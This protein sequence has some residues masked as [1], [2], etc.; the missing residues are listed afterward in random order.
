MIAA[1]NSDP[2]E[3]KFT[4]TVLLNEIDLDFS[5]LLALNTET[6][7]NMQLGPLLHTQTI[8]QCLMSAAEILSFTE[9]SISVADVVPPSLTGF[10]DSGI[11][12]IVTKGAE[13]LFDMYES[14]LLKAMPNF[15]HT[16]VR[17]K[18]NAF[19][20]NSLQ[21]LTV[22]ENDSSV[23]G[24]IDFRDLFLS[25]E[26][27][28]SEGASGNSPYGNVVNWVWDLVNTV[29]FSAN[30]SGLLAMND[31][32]IKPLTKA[33]SGQEGLVS[34]NHSLVDLKK[35]HFRH[36]IWNAFADHLRLGMSNLRLNGLDTFREP[37]HIIKPS[38]KSG[39]VLENHITLG[40]DEKSLDASFQFDI[41]VGS[42]D[43]PIATKNTMDLQV[44]LPSN[45]EVVADLFAAVDASQFMKMPLKNI[46][47]V[48]CWLSMMAD[49]EDSD[50]VKLALHYFDMVFD[51]FTAKSSCISCSNKALKDFDEMMDFLDANDFFANVNS[52]GRLIL[53]EILE[54]DWMG[55]LFDSEIQAAALRCPSDSDLT[56]SQI[57]ENS[58][59][60]ETSRQLVDGILY[61]SMSVAQIIAVVLAQKHADVELPVDVAIELDVP[62]DANLID[63]TNL[64]NV[65]SWA[66]MALEEANAYLGSV[67]N[68]NEGKDVLG[69]VNILRSLILDDDGLFTIDIANQGFEAGGVVL[70]L[71][72]VSLIG[73]DSFTSFDV[74]NATGA[75][76]LK[77]TAKL[78]TL[79]VS[80]SMGLSVGE[81]NELETITASL[82]LK[83]IEVDVSFLVALDEGVLGDLKLGSIMDTSNI[84]YCIRSA[85]HTIGE[86]AG[87]VDLASLFCSLPSSIH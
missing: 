2:I 55:G 73:L 26:I 10:L 71:Y 76:Q 53:S 60:F 40:I 84:F 4:V 27:A 8:M 11:D 6:L 87:V 72:N 34:F 80:V 83:D 35:E 64:T 41:E 32:L 30:E 52:R 47:N 58:F 33:Q 25:P 62:A 17:E 9:L 22:C 70:S 82:V 7:G 45:I 66:D 75:Q 74:L 50:A 37:F 21:V 12:K 5:F 49:T 48:N 18:L 13:A 44:S 69:I 16:F 43:S 78:D 29:L 3:E 24:L 51:D 68:N 57:V 15:F 54:S 19:V 38:N 56:S 77:N 65:A 39:R 14:V 28:S 59:P 85:I 20:K 61:A 79:G 81:G 36:D 1:P 86:C 31:I 46:L 67:Q 63:F 42:D 23:N